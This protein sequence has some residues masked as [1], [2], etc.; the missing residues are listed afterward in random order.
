MSKA[1]EYARALIARAS[2]TPDD[3]GCQDWLAERLAALGFTLERIDRGGVRNLW[4]RRGSGAPLICFA[5]HTDVVPTGPLEKWSYPPFAATLSDGYL[6]GRGAADMKGSIAAFLA[7]VESFLAEHPEPP[8]SL[9]WLITSDEEGPA[10]DGTVRVVEHLAGRGERIDYCI[11][12][13]PTCAERFGDTLKNGRRG[14]LHGRLVVQGLQ[15]HIAYPQLACNP[16]HRAAPALAELATT[17][18]D[19]GNEFFPPT[20]WQISNIHAGTGAVNVIPGSL[21]VRFNF[22]FSTASTVENLKERVHALLDRHGLDY[23]LDWELGARPFLT[24]RGALVE[25]L[26]RAIL[27]T[28]GIEP[29]LSTTGGTSDGRFIADI[30]AEVVEFGPVNQ[31]IHKIDECVGVDELAQLTTVYRKTLE[32]LL[33]V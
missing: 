14:S 13:E 7:A 29:I 11:V 23:T 31:T 32:G 26:S 16:V 20:T 30:C 18:W 12:G 3:A 19:P 21:E 4:A 22:R 9:A 25:A 6:Y 33:H 28:C 1:L 10:V 17:E 8:G 15:G 27:D 5:G 24:P 2:L